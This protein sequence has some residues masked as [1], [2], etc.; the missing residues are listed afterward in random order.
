M[1]KWQAIETGGGFPGWMADTG[2]RWQIREVTA[3]FQVRRTHAFQD[4]WSRPP[5][6]GI[7][8]VAARLAIGNHPGDDTPTCQCAANGKMREPGTPSRV[9]TAKISINNVTNTN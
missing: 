4:E 3:P 5:T 7:C 9:R 8:G 1:A 2:D 6:S